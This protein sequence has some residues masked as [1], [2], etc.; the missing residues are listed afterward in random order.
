MALPVIYECADPTCQ[1][2]L[3]LSVQQYEEIRANS[4]HF[5]NVPGHQVAAQ[6]AAAL[7]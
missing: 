2:I 3:R 4:R 1:D 6:G 5:L 7:G